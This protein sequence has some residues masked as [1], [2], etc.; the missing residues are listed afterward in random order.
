MQAQEPK[1]EFQF[2]L[3]PFWPSVA[4]SEQASEKLRD[5]N[6]LYASFPL[7]FQKTLACV[8]EQ[9]R[10]NPSETR[11]T[12]AEV[13]GEGDVPLGIRLSYKVS[14]DILTLCDIWTPVQPSLFAVPKS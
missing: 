9:H 10:T 11:I 8:L 5:L 2:S 1:K 6:I 14:N 13:V 4:I 7:A 12:V 3:T